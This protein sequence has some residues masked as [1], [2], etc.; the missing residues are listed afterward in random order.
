MSSLWFGIRNDSKVITRSSRVD[1]RRC[2]LGR[3]AAKLFW[4][5]F[6]ASPCWRRTR[7]P[8]GTRPLALR[9]GACMLMAS[10]QL[11]SCC[12]RAASASQGMAGDS[13]SQC[14]IIAYKIM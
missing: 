1:F 4:S 6:G 2:L 13:P 7:C 10:R 5:A 9:P 11:A 3:L 12:S 8:T 14:L